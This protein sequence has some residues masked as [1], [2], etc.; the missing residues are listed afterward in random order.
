MSDMN[1]FDN[2]A[3]QNIDPAKL[4]MLLSMS[5]QAKGKSQADL[6]RRFR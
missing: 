2:P 1:W 3:L 6:H 5:D 4:Q